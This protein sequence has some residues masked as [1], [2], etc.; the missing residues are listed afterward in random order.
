MSKPWLPSIRLRRGNLPWWFAFVRLWTT[1]P[2]LAIAVAV[3][4]GMGHVL[5][6]VVVALALVTVGFLHSRWARAQRARVRE[7]LETEPGY[8]EEYNRRSDRIMRIFGWYFAGIGSLVVL[9][10]IAW[11]IARLA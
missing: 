10:V 6:G 3:G 5:V 2:I 11:L 4:Y 9:A 1:G 7:R 8:R